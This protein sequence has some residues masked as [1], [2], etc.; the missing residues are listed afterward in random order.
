[1]GVFPEASQGLG[2]PEVMPS[3]VIPQPVAHLYFEQAA[4]WPI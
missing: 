1:V 4:F 2:T 3:Q